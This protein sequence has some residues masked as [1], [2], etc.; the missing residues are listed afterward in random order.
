M[1]EIAQTM[2]SADAKVWTMKLRPNVKFTDGTPYDASAVKFNWDRQ[3][4]PANAS[5]WALT[6]KTLTFRVIDR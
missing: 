3:A 5:P 6:F 2:T 1:P 4:D